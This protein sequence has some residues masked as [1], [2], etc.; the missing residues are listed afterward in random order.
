MSSQ[1][2]GSKVYPL[3]PTLHAGEKDDSTNTLNFWATMS[4]AAAVT[5]L[6]EEVHVDDDLLAKVVVSM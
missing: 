3:L 2:S 6:D 5:L 1:H 4:V